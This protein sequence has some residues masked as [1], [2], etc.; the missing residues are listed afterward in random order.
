MALVINDHTPSAICFG[1]AAVQKLLYNGVQ[2]WPDDAPPEYSYTGAHQLMDDGDGNWRILL[3]SSGTLTLERDW[4]T[5]LFLVG[6]GAG[7]CDR[8]VADA[9]PIC[10]GPGGGGGYTRTVRNVI[11]AANMAY[12]VV[13]GA[14]GAAG[15]YLT[16]G[17]LGS[18]GGTTEIAGGDLRYTAAGGS[19]G[20]LIGTK[21]C[22]GGDGG[23]GGGGESV[24]GYLKSYRGPLGG[25]DGG[26]SRALDGSEMTQEADGSAFF[27][28]GQGTTTRAFGEADGACY[29]GGGGCGVS[30]AYSSEHY[31]SGGDGGGGYGGSF[32]DSGGSGAA[33]TGGGGGGCGQGATYSHGGAGGSGIVIIRRAKA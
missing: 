21:G 25:Q 23:S 30:Q 6:G 32:S 14:G 26:N 5:D 31:R 19:P 10:G 13:I 1:E 12:T 22:A 29:G 17:H 15:T 3:T 7:G 18:S 4:E 8:L 24:Y 16:G 28:H 27:G 9:T 20:S 11:L 33:N 2:V